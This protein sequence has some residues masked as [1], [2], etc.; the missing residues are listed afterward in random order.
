MNVGKLYQIKQYFWLLYPSKEIAAPDE[1]G[2]LRLGG[3]TRDRKDA[4]DWSD[5]WSRKLNCNVTYIPEN[6]IF[7]LLE[8]DGKFLKILS[9]NGEI[10]WIKYPTNEEW[11]KGS[12]EEVAQE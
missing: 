10:G 6:S 9:T 2:G 3:A 8:E 5:Y 4:V 7:F 11:N 12:I 1:I